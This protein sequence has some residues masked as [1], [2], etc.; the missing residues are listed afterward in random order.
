MSSRRLD[1]MKAKLPRLF[2]VYDAAVNE[3]FSAYYK[4][5]VAN[6]D[7]DHTAARAHAAAADELEAGI[8][9]LATPC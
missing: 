5:A 3:Y 9:R 6:R 1:G 7:G 8:T 4:G 2:E